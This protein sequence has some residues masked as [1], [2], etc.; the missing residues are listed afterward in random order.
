MN[1]VA[2]TLRL[3][4]S[5]FEAAKEA[6]NIHVREIKNAVRRKWTGTS[7]VNNLLW[8]RRSKPGDCANNMKSLSSALL[9]PPAILFPDRGIRHD[10][11][12]VPGTKYCVTQ[13][14]P[15][16]KEK[17]DVIDEFFRAK[18]EAGMVLESKSPHSTPTFLSKS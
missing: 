2:P 3:S 13:Q 14:W 6:V 18:H 9:N 12:L 10:I 15:L 11:G 7:R 4:Y 8:M 16:P 1:I 5:S 17:C